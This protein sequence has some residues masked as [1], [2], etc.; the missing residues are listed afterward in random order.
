VRDCTL[1]HLV[2]RGVL[3]FLIHGYI[4]TRCAFVAA[5]VAF[6]CR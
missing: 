6:G 5:V 4:V 3:D 2:L 1:T